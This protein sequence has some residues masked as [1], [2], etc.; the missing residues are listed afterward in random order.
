[1]GTILSRNNTYNFQIKVMHDEGISKATL[2]MTFLS[3][4][5]SNDLGVKAHG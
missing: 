5:K 1:M 3:A 2:Y 4:I